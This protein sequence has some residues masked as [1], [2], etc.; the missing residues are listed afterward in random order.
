MRAGYLFRKKSSA[1]YGARRS[2]ASLI[3]FINEFPHINM[4]KVTT[5]DR[6][7]DRGRMYPGMG[8]YCLGLFSCK[9]L[10]S[11]GKRR[12]IRNESKLFC[13]QGR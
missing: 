10:G 7:S 5:G 11:G 12:P 2:L 1:R 8:L 6:F 13:H 3:Y 9:A 4:E